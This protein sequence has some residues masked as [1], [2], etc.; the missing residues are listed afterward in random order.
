LQQAL[1]RV[2]KTVRDL[3]FV[4]PGERCRLARLMHVM[5]QLCQEDIAL[6]GEMGLLRLHRGA[7]GRARTL[8]GVLHHFHRTTQ[9]LG[10]RVLATP[11]A[12]ARGLLRLARGIE[13]LLGRI[14]GGCERRERFLG[15]QE[16]LVTGA[17]RLKEGDTRVPQRMLGFHHLRQCRRPAFTA[18]LWTQAG[19]VRIDAERPI[20]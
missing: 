8:D 10:F 19:A 16:C 2:P 18:G 5:P 12:L 17:V 9:R 11:K 7:V 14:E 4:V 20:T 15:G 6:R 3:A 1:D 13:G